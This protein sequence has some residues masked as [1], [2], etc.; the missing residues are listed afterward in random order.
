MWFSCISSHNLRANAWWTGKILLL[1]STDSTE[2]IQC[3]Q[4]SFV[5]RLKYYQHVRTVFDLRQKFSKWRKK[6]P[7]PLLKN[8][9]SQCRCYF[10]K[11]EHVL[12]QAISPDIHWF[13]KAEVHSGQLRLSPFCMWHRERGSITSIVNLH[14]LYLLHLSVL[15]LDGSPA[16]RLPQQNFHLALP[17]IVGCHPLCRHGG[18]KQLRHDDPSDSLSRGNVFKL[19]HSWG[20]MEWALNEGVV[21]ICWA[22]HDV[23][24]GSKPK[25]PPQQTCRMAQIEATKSLPK[26]PWC[27]TGAWCRPMLG[28]KSFDILKPFSLGHS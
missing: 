6:T 24:P 23:G 28:N 5:D 12:A 2:S 17:T 15:F 13:I 16:T 14:L 4:H 25:R 7:D 3:H 8:Q 9:T 18:W 1:L 26:M 19:G 21:E 10:L 22:T 11:K 27:L 20:G